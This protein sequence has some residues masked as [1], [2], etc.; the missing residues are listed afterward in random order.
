[1]GKQ[2]EVDNNI[3]F[4]PRPG[5]ALKTYLKRVINRPLGRTGII[6]SEGCV[7]MEITNDTSGIV[8]LFDGLL[9]LAAGTTYPRANGTL[10]SSDGT[11]FINEIEYTFAAG[12]LLDETLTVTF[13]KYVKID[14]FDTD[15][16]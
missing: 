13:S 3:E 9:D 5:L 4:N 16:K 11:P 10:Y 14:T 8:T 2:I 15:L 1:M 6:Y 7:S 12:A